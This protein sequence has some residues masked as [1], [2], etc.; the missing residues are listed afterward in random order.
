MFDLGF[1]SATASVK[2][3]IESLGSD[4]LPLSSLLF[5]GWV[6]LSPSFTSSNE[7]SFWRILSLKILFLLLKLRISF[8]CLVISVSILCFSSSKFSCRS[9]RFPEIWCRT[10]FL[11]ANTLILKKVFH[12]SYMKFNLQT[13]SY[14]NFFWNSW[15]WIVIKLWYW[16]FTQIENYPSVTQMSN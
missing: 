15:L 10:W 14:K 3:S 4:S 7:P 9:I 6:H 8:F 16:Y 1:P 13:R 11:A 12:F 5:P 2:V